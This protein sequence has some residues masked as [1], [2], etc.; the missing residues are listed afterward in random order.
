ML[1][2]Y[3][4]IT[5]Y[6]KEKL[7]KKKSILQVHQ[8]EIQMNEFNGRGKRPVYWKLQNTKE[9]NTSKW[10]DIAFTWIGKK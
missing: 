5:N 4:V 3:V 6:E 9:R 1:Y 10:K 7:K 8:K 2:F